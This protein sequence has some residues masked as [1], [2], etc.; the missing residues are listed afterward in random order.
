MCEF[1]I[2]AAQIIDRDNT[3][4]DVQWTVVLVTEPT[5]TLIQ[6]RFKSQ[7]LQHRANEYG[8]DIENQKKT[9]TMVLH[10]PSCY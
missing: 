8:D 1:L 5:N 2:V 9:N 10:R 6:M 7:D 3:E 4:R